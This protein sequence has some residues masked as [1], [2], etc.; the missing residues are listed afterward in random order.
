MCEQSNPINF[1]EDSQRGFCSW[2]K[3][4]KCFLTTPAKISGIKTKI[5]KHTETEGKRAGSIA[6][7]Q[8]RGFCLH[9]WFST[10][11]SIKWILH[12]EK[13]LVLYPTLQQQHT[14]VSL[15]S[16]RK[17]SRSQSSTQAGSTR[18]S[19]TSLSQHISTPVL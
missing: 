8:F 19:Y 5:C 12:V 16:R 7:L 17:S 3:L 11:N 10:A 15:Q 13:A 9:Q 2:C 4:M 1:K 18:D 6:L 14:I